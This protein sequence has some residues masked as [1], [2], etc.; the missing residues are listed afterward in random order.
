MDGQHGERVMI[1]SHLA[2]SFLKVSGNNHTLVCDP[3]Q[4]TANMGSWHSFPIFNKNDLYNFV[5]D[6]DTV[7]ISHLHS[8][9]FDAKFLTESELINK[10]F[11]IKDFNNNHLVSRLR[12]LGIENIIEAKPFT[13]V[14][15]ENDFEIMI[16]PQLN[17]NTSAIKDDVNYDLDTSIAIKTKDTVFFNQVDNPLTAKNM[18]LIKGE[19]NRSFGNID[20]ACFCCGAASDYPQCYINIE[21]EEEKEI[22]VSSYLDKIQ[23]YNQILKPKFFFPAGGG[24]VHPGRMAA[25]NSYIA[26]PDKIELRERFPNIIFLD[27]GNTADFTEKD[28]KFYQSV[29]P[30][31]LT[32]NDVAKTLIKFEYERHDCSWDSLNSDFEVALRNYRKRLL[33]N[34]LIQEWNWTF[35]VYEKLDFSKNNI[36][37]NPIGVLHAPS[38]HPKVDI[39]FHLEK[40]AI[41]YFLNKGNVWNQFGSYLCKRTPNTFIPES[42]FS[43]NYLTL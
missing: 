7:Y 31:P 10:R 32:K 22:I 40:S 18:E 4:G 23:S 19:I 6:A 5:R 17:S 3:W 35:V 24:Y 28:P 12:K 34:N 25:L 20:L 9:H 26:H 27:G 11:L 39:E 41:S 42:Y 30:L 2:N 36:L 37:S 8:D 33:D 38:P 16:F 15:L 29:A 43:L 14:V 13:K 21:R 1:V